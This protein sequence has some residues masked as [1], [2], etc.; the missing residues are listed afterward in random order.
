MRE[1]YLCSQVTTPPY[2]TDEGISISMDFIDTLDTIP[3]P[4][5]SRQNTVSLTT[6]LRQAIISQ[7]A[8]WEIYPILAVAC[9]LHLFKLTTSEFDADQA[10]LLRLAHDAV[11]HGLFP[12]TGNISSINLANPPGYT[13]LIM[14]ITLLTPDPLAVIV[15]TA[16]LN[17]L[18]VVL[19]YIFVRRYYGRLA[20]SVAALLYGTTF[21]DIF[22]G[23]FIWQPN[24][25][26]FFTLILFF[27]FFRGA[28]ERKSG[29]FIWALPL[30]GFICQLHAIAL[31][32]ACP[33]CLTLAIA[34]HT[35]RRRDLALG[36]FFLALIFSPYLLW[37]TQSHFSDISLLL[38][39]SS[40]PSSIDNQVFLVYMKFLTSYV[41]SSTSSSVLLSNVLSFVYPASILMY[42]LTLAAFL[43]ASA[44]LLG[45]PQIDLLHT[46][47]FSTQVVPLQTEQSRSIWQALRQSWQ[48]LAATPQRASLLLLLSWQLF[49]LLL[50]LHHS[51]GLQPQYLLILLPGP[52]ILLGLLI[53]Q[54]T[55]WSLHIPYP[56]PRLL[57]S[58]LVPALS[59]LLVALQFCGS[60]AWF[61]NEAHGQHIRG[62]IYTTFQDV[63]RAANAADQ[64]ARSHHLDRLY[65][66]TDQYTEDTLSY[67]SAQMHTPTTILNSSS[68]LILPATTQGPA[69]LLLGPAETLDQA[70]LA[71]FTSA[72]LISEPPRLGGPP[73]K[74]YI[75]YPL[76]TTPDSQATFTQTLRLN[77][78]RPG[79]LAWNNPDHPDQPT[80]HLFETVWTNLKT[81]PPTT[82]TLYTYH[83][84]ALYSGNGTNGETGKADCGFT[85]ITPG[86]H[87]F[88]PFRLPADSTALP[89]QLS[90]SGSILTT[91]PYSP[92]YGPF[93]LETSETSKAVLAPLQTTSGHTSLLIQN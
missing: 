62:H 24:L 15:F 44:G 11:T 81:L 18:A 76:P 41:D 51:I 53:S 50:L 79:T 80:T 17:T 27:L 25:I 7:L 54:L 87:I 13:F 52:F 29:W 78:S 49:P 72:Q 8:A 28:V 1:G 36:I 68:C 10:V 33:F 21:W 19:T 70:L 43:L 86:E 22:Y 75:L 3:I 77:T 31:Y 5:V 91:M 57:L 64:L 58:L 16:L 48:R 69:V 67:L 88:V 32:L 9:F 6:R 63:Q 40:Y 26:P 83:F 71:R 89:T 35:V 14:P 37:E 55:V 60:L 61:I 65:I 66:Y 4:T 85:S 2:F 59:L 34:Y 45:W 23:R 73:F 46:S 38:H 42:A 56:Q 20:G 39:A 82:N 84:V 30:L 92:S 90:I 93:T 12:V 74:L 47:R